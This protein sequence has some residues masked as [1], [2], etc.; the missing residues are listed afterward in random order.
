MQKQSNIKNYLEGPEMTRL[1][2]KAREIKSSGKVFSDVYDANGNQY[3]DL[4]QEGGGV[5]GVALVGYTYILE[6]AGIRFYSLGGTSAGAIN[7]MFMAGLAK[8]GEPVS[9]KILGIL[10]QKNFFDFVDGPKGIKKLVQRKVEERGGLFWSLLFNSISIYYQLRYKLGL[11]PGKKLENWINHHLVEAGINSYADLKQKREN[12]HKL[13][14]REEREI[15]KPRLAI[16]SSEITTHTKVDFPRMAHLYWKDVEK[17]HPAQFVK[18]SIAIP[19]FFY[20]FLKKDIPNA[21]VKAHK[22]WIDF[23]GYRGE[24]PPEVKFVDGGLLSNFPINV[25]HTQKTP[26]LPT[27]GVRLSVYRK[28]YSSTTGVFSLGGAMIS[29]MRQIYDYDFLLRNPDYKQLICHIDA[30]LQYNWLNFDMSFQDQKNLLLM[31]AKKGLEFLQTFDW[32]NYKAIRK[33][34]Q[35]PK[36]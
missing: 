30:D 17:I 24:I 20:P 5:L 34:M 8:M 15:S 13:Y 9:V 4:V 32:I 29:T 28:E 6:Q 14:H 3:V 1:V 19:Y 18:A 16:I 23:A 25:F 7:A 33:K 22:E 26:S 10:G 21:G 2:A 35:Y 12:F 36:I 11:N 31:G 27:F